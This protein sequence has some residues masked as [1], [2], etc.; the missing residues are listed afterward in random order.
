MRHAP[1]WVRFLREASGKALCLTLVPNM[2]SGPARK[3][4]EFGRRARR[5][6]LRLFLLGWH[7]LL[8]ASIINLMSNGE[9]FRALRVR[10]TAGEFV[11]AVEEC[12]AEDLPPGDV[13]IAVRYS[14]LNYKDALS[15]FGNRGVT[16]EYPHTPGID[17]AGVVVSDTSG[18]LSEGTEVLVHGHDLGAN[19]WGGFSELIRVP[20]DWVMPLP[21]GLSLRRAAAY[22]TAGFTAAQSVLELEE[23]GI[24]PES[25]EVLVTGAS[26]GVGSI[27]VAVL[28]RLGYS[29]VGV[30]GKTGAGQRLR[31]F[32][33]AQVIGREEA[34]EQSGRPL[35]KGRWAGVVDTV[36]GEILST[37]IRSTKY[38]GCVTACGNAASGE[39]PMTVYP[40]ILRA[41]KLVGIDSAH[42]PE[43]RR[44]AVWQRLA[45]PWAVTE[46]LDTM[47]SETDLDHLD[48][49]ITVILSGGIDGRILVHL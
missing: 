16:R 41:V 20:R 42:V 10:E 43:D 1:A 44:R 45:E 36:G 46:A 15:A 9:R 24:G 13:T 5:G 12:S 26:G 31:R 27:A 8:D 4:P 11:R 14:S 3:A 23:Q 2:G 38:R 30:S 21:A 17:A 40:F 25:G 29:V 7:A 18:S 47:T 33:A 32:G 37:A 6:R 49:W 34:V 35:L 39:L 28:G 19:T 48:Y 22:G